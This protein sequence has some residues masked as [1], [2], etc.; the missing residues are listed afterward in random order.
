MY[1]LTFVMILLAKSGNYTNLICRRKKTRKCFYI[2][3]CLSVCL[4]AAVSLSLSLSFFMLS[5]SK[6]SIS[7]LS[8]FPLSL[9]FLFLSLTLSSGYVECEKPNNR[10]HKFVGSLTWNNEKMSLDNDQILLR[11]SDYNNNNNNNN[12]NNDNDS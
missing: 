11:V 3:F 10:L 4:Y 8:P 7:S 6:L 12:N 2:P 1:V 9:P 5:F